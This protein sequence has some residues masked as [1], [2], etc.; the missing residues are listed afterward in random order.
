[1]HYCIVD[2]LLGR[3][4][5][6]GSEHG[7]SFVA[8]G[9]D[10]TALERE[11]AGEFP[12]LVCLPGSALTTGWA[13]AIAAHL[14]G[15]PRRLTLPLDLRG[16]PFQQR[17]WKLL[18]TIPYGA[19]TTYT[20]LAHTLGTPQAARA[21]GRACATNPA[22]IVVPCHRVTGSDGSLR[23]YRWGLERKRRL[24]EHERKQAYSETESV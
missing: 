16:S 8:L 13:Q 14:D 5:V 2:S 10:D 17:V 9:D 24:I 22:S 6:A 1:M 12:G 11:L 18:C 23:G 15:E 4:L 3:L 7:I 21:V 19:T 20:M